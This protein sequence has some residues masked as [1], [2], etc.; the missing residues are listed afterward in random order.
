MEIL[1]D[2]LYIV[3]TAAVPLLTTYLCKFLY[4]KWTEGQ[5]H[6]KNEHVSAVLD[7]VVS[8]VLNCVERTTQTFVDELKKKGEFTED[9]A[10]EAFNMTKETALAML[11]VEAIKII[12]EVYGNV[13]IYLDTL[14]ES[15]VK[16][17]K[18]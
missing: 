11:S 13:D 16:Q 15:L 9:A 4:T 17:L 3:I 12:T 7:Q 14:I 2:I 6:I 18:K 8:M 1:R 5:A 10:K